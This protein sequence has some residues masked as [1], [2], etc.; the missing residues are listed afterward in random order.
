[1]NESDKTEAIQGL[2]KGFLE[3]VGSDFV[4]ELVYQFLLTRGD[5]LGGS[6]RNVG[7]ALATRKF[8]RTLL[9]ILT[10]AGI[11]YHWFHSSAKT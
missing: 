4:E 11:P 8:T 7:G 9:A 6:M 2:I 1:M 3:P 5:T 10:L